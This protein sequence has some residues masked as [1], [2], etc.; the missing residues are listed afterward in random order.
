M[1]DK[2]EDTESKQSKPWLFKPGESGNPAG[3]PKGARSKFAQEFVFAFAEDFARHGSD[4]IEKVRIEDPST[5]L[6]TACAIL[7]KVIELDDE[8]LTAIKD[9]SKAMPFDAIRYR[10]QDQSEK[11]ATTH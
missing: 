7:P 3:R 4:V 2:T 6:R 10:T 11:P 1:S 9:L 5:Y 8:T